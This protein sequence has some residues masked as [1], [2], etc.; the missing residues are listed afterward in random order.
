LPFGGNYDEWLTNDKVNQIFNLSSFEKDFK[1]ANDKNVFYQKKDDNK[2]YVLGKQTDFKEEEVLRIV[3]TA[4]LSGKCTNDEI[5][6]ALNAQLI[7]KLLLTDAIK[8]AERNVNVEGKS[9]EELKEALEKLEK[10]TLKDQEFK[11]ALNGT[12]LLEEIEKKEQRGTMS[13]EENKS[14]RQIIIENLGK[15]HNIDRQL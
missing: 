9:S 8:D 11:D 13:V 12:G 10:G 14:Y 7:K 6:E 1:K 15:R 4:T 5:E 3:G 2:F